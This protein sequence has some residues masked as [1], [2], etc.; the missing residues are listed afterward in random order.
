MMV[1][2]WFSDGFMVMF[3]CAGK[4]WTR[5]GFQM[6]ANLWSNDGM[7][8][9][10]RCGPSGISLGHRFFALGLMQLSNCFALSCA[11]KAA[12]GTL[13]RHNADAPSNVVALHFEWC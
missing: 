11:M 2:R 6:V 10:C 4:H 9:R 8:H 5:F 12:S 13:A 3:L 7:I 1:L